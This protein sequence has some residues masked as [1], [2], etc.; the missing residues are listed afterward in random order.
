MTLVHQLRKVGVE[1]SMILLVLPLGSP[2]IPAP[3]T[4]PQRQ[5]VSGWGTSFLLAKF[6]HHSHQDVFLSSFI[7]IEMFCAL[8]TAPLKLTPT[9][10]SF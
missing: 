6:S 1:I 7:H 2:N 10:I 5:A 3:V 9:D 8:F 4:I